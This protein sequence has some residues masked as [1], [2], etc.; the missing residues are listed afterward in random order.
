MYTKINDF[1]DKTDGTSAHFL[2]INS[3]GFQ[4]EKG[5]TT[6][7]RSKG[8]QDYHFLYVTSGKY[9]VHT[10]NGEIALHPGDLLAYQPFE[11][12]LYSCVLGMES[13]S[14]WVHFTG[15][16]A[17]DL[18]SS[19]GFSEKQVF[20]VGEDAALQKAFERMIHHYEPGKQ[21]LLSISFLIQFCTLASEQKKEVLRTDKR[22]SA[23]LSYMN[24]HYTDNYSNDFY[25]KLCD[26]SETRFS[27]LFKEVMGVSP[28][29]YCLRLKLDRAQY[30]LLYSDMTVSEIADNLGFSDALYFSRLFKKYKKQA[31]LSFRQTKG[32]AM[33]EA[34]V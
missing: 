26:M 19:T 34:E 15:T 22:I 31:P 1:P 23:A 8:R 16:G 30:L 24:S 12:Q 33:Q 17:Q 3:C 10:K 5:G 14:F 18:L 21:N 11:K 6:I 29:R 28:H 7:L 25:A 13:S 32:V 20:H 2:H 9:I 27:H 4:R